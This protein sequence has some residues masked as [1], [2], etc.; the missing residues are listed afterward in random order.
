[1]ARRQEVYLHCDLEEE[2]R[3][4]RSSACRGGG[5]VVGPLLAVLRC[6]CAA[7]LVLAAVSFAPFLFFAGRTVVLRH[8]LSL[9]AKRPFCGN[10]FFFAGRTSKKN[11]VWLRKPQLTP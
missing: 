1:M 8:R 7:L 2:E 6:R 4:K 9:L 3:K 5:S 10:D 11:T